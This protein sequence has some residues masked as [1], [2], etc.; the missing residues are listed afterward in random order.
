MAVGDLIDEV[1][2]RNVVHRARGRTI[3]GKTRDRAGDMHRHHVED[4]CC[5]QEGRQAQGQVGNQPSRR[6][7][8]AATD[9]HR[10]DA[11]LGTA[12]KSSRARF[13]PTVRRGLGRPRGR[14]A[15]SAASLSGVLAI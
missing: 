8:Q 1:G 12:G 7:S 4:R 15:E 11:V 14:F 9:G 3:T 5:E 2:V 6:P 13:R 10:G